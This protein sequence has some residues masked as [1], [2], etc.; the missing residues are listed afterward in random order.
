V[1]SQ[2]NSGHSKQYFTPFVWAQLHMAQNLFSLAMHPTLPFGQVPFRILGHFSHAIPQ[3]PTF[4]LIRHAVVCW[5]LVKDFLF[6][7]LS[8]VFFF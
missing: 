7:F 3:T 1:V 4:M 2:G 6:G 8:L 5:G